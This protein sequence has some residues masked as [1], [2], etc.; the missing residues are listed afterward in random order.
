MELN[1]KCR[2]T[3]LQEDDMGEHQGNLRSGGVFLDTASMVW[4]MKGRMNELEFLKILKLKRAAL[5][6]SF[7]KNEKTIY[8]MENNI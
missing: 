3:K 6:K 2:I 5:S 4:S 8:I 7:Q 1:V